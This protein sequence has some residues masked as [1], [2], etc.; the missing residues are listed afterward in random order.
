MRLLSMNRDF[1]FFGALLFVLCAAMGLVLSV[2]HF[3]IGERVFYLPTFSVWFVLM[4]IV[5][6]LALFVL[7]KY[8]Q[9]K[10]Y[11]ITFMLALV[12]VISLVC[13]FIVIYTMMSARFLEG[14][15]RY[16]YP[17]VLISVVLYSISLIFSNAG[18]RP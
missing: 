11:S 8:Y 15:F 12:Y 7:L 17:L 13:H 6:I 18:R 9:Y 2:V 14:L 1:Y 10:R 5:N 16:T 3:K 4:V